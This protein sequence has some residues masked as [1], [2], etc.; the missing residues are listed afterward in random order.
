MCIARIPDALNLAIHVLI[1][2][3]H[4]SFSSLLHTLAPHQA[5]QHGLD[6][7]QARLDHIQT[8]HHLFMLF[9]L[10]FTMLTTAVLHAAMAAFALL[11]FAFMRT[12]HFV[13]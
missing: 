11:T 7:G 3:F 13:H 4:K 9:M 5:L 10:S 1:G 6:L 2:V 12:S 8:F